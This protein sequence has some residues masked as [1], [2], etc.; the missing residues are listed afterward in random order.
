VRL[1][2]TGQV[3][4]AGAGITVRQETGA[5]TELFSE[6]EKH[7]QGRVLK[8]AHAP[9]WRTYHTWN[10]MHS[11]G[12]YPDLTLVRRGRLIFAE[13]KSESGKVSDK[14]QA[15]IDDLRAAGAECHIWRP[16]DMDEIEKVLK[17]E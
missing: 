16:S 8:L 4:K 10:S 13:L 9:R 11:T 1:L 2:G 12:G 15:W 5:L 6:T 17:R 14:Q 7:F 3:I